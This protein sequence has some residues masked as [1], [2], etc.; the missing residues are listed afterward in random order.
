MDRGLSKTY[1]RDTEDRDDDDEMLFSNPALQAHLTVPSS[2]IVAL[3]EEPTTCG[4]TQENTRLVW[5]TTQEVVRTGQDFFPFALCGEVTTKNRGTTKKSCNAL[6]N[7]S[8]EGDEYQLCCDSANPRAKRVEF[9]ASLCEY[10]DT[11]SIQDIGGQEQNEAWD[12]DLRKVAS[13]I[14]KLPERHSPQNTGDELGDNDLLQYVKFVSTEESTPL[15]ENIR[16]ESLTWQVL[17]VINSMTETI[18]DANGVRQDLHSLQNLSFDEESRGI[19]G[20]FSIN[21]TIQAMNIHLGDECLL[22]RALSFLAD[23]CQSNSH[24]KLQMGQSGVQTIVDCIQSSHNTTSQVT[25]R[26]CNAL[27]ICCSSCPFN[28]TTAGKVGAIQAILTTIRRCK[29][30]MQL[31]EQCLNTLYY[32]THNHLHNIFLLEEYGGCEEI[33]VTCRH[34]AFDADLQAV[35]LNLV[36][37]LLRKSPHL[38]VSLP[39]TGLVD[40]IARML[41]LYYTFE[42]YIVPCS[43]TLRYL[44]FHS[45]TRHT[46]STTTIIQTL[47]CCLPHYFA[48][49]SILHPVLLALGN[50][51]YHPTLSKRHACNSKSLSTLKTILTLHRTHTMLAEQSLRLLRNISDGPSSVRRLCLRHNMAAYVAQ[52]MCTLPGAASLQEHGAATLINLSCVGA[53]QIRPYLS[54]QHLRLAL[55]LHTGSKSTERQLLFLQQI[56]FPRPNALTKLFSRGTRSVSQASSTTT[57]P[58]LETLLCGETVVNALKATHSTN[59]SV[60]Y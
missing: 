19:I 36:Q 57:A 48:E 53:Q 35:A 10:D 18:G 4:R 46:I 27:R 44:A 49:K 5:S 33:V 7:R 24:N 11:E 28:Q 23:L 52:A 1:S 2:K 54:E 3:K 47:A 15:M 40:D 43:T 50:L 9:E 22:E 55:S 56:F 17:Q 16:P 6:K 45:P 41:P 8:S 21:I 25:E 31:Q 12:R 26:A 34:F 60:E 38:R 58:K 42:P 14:K 29:D 37:S 59:S 51:T 32:L 39:T 20:R 13:I 30:S